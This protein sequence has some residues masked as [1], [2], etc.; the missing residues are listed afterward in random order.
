[1]NLAAAFMLV[2]TGC[3]G[4]SGNAGASIESKT[5][6][7]ALRSLVSGPSA[8][9]ASPLVRTH[10]TVGFADGARGAI[11]HY[12]VPPGP[13]GSRFEVPEVVAAAPGPGMDVFA[14][15]GTSRVNVYP[16]DGGGKLR[17]APLYRIAVPL[18]GCDGLAFD[19]A[20]NLY[21]GCADGNGAFEVAAYVPPYGPASKPVAVF[22]AGSSSFEGSDPHYFAFD[23]KDEL[24][25]ARSS[26]NE[27]D[28]WKGAPAHP[29]MVR[30]IVGLSYPNGLAI[31]QRDELYVANLTTS[32][33]AAYSPGAHGFPAPDRVISDS[34]DRF[35]QCLLHGLAVVGDRLFA[36]AGAVYE[37][38]SQKD[39]DQ[40]ALAVLGRAGPPCEDARSVVA[41][42]R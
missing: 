32:T 5:R 19:A 23:S 38:N 31:D 1:M 41:S 37:F 27:I 33:I 35:D 28:V 18:I 9:L 21:V 26:Q 2:L 36:G 8:G 25:I 11:E 17:P 34:K 24:Y 22:T 30:S 39:G 3:S 10:L 7:P 40:R 20:E 13:P 12:A 15:L 6:L 14:V 4:I 42:A 16:P 29:V